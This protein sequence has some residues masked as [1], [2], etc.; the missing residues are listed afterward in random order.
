MYVSRA[1][2]RCL[3]NTQP[4]IPLCNSTFCVPQKWYCRRPS[5]VS[6]LCR[7]RDRF[8][9]QNYLS[10][11]GKCDHKGVIW[12]ISPLASISWTFFISSILQVW[13]VNFK[14]LHCYWCIFFWVGLFLI[15]LEFVPSSETALTSS[16][17]EHMMHNTSGWS[18]LCKTRFST[19]TKCWWSCLA[20]LAAHI[21]CMQE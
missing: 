5:Q 14:S 15:R 7:Y 3:A 11:Y 12:A 10:K 1:E 18:S 16:P 4:H 8:N 6:Q 2:H 9:A 21:L 19:T 20:C 17:M 13:I